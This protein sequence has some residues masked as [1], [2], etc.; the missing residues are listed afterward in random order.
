MPK[1]NAYPKFSSFPYPGAFIAVL[2]VLALIPGWL[3]SGRSEGNRST[4]LA[5]SQ[6][7]SRRTAQPQASAAA[8]T[9][10]WG[11][12]SPVAPALEGGVL[13]AEERRLGGLSDARE[14][15]GSRFEPPGADEFPSGVPQTTEALLEEAEMVAKSA[16]RRY[17]ESILAQA[18]LAYWQTF[19]GQAE[20]AEA[21]WQ[22]ILSRE[23]RFLDAYAE[24]I[25]LAEKRNALGEVVH[26][27]RRV[28]RLAPQTEW[29]YL[30]LAQALAAQGRD[31]EAAAVLQE[32]HAQA[33]KPS[34]AVC[35]MLGG[36]L[37]RLGRVSEA[38]AVLQKAEA[39]APGDPE[40]HRLLADLA[41]SRG[42]AD[43]AEEHLRRASQ[44]VAAQPAEPSGD[45][46]LG[47]LVR[48]VAALETKAGKMYYAHRDFL[49]T[50]IYL[51][52][53][54]AIDPQYIEAHRAL[55]AFYQEQ[56]RYLE[57]EQQLRDWLRVEP[58]NLRIYITLA[59]L[60]GGRRDFAK[61]EA[62]LEEAT[63]K[64]PNNPLPFAMLAKL[65]IDARQKTE[66]AVPLAEKVVA[67]QPIAINY[68]LLAEAFE[69]TGRIPE[70]LAA[71]EKAI[72]L[73]RQQPVFAAVRKRLLDRAGQ[74]AVEN[75][76]RPAD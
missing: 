14:Q 16:V 64:F 67:L 37:V 11:S 22:A 25:K 1:S 41:A 48:D 5:H 20:K 45:D 3:L 8:G 10:P 60:Y 68:Q 66:Q 43:R 46:Q 36:L 72:A 54:V 52:R 47:E 57:M 23:E 62:T 2:F 17:P 35:K 61:T 15:P 4:P 65:Y 51:R 34:A 76:P 55:V 6:G 26:L 53:A 19:T 40:V 13:S 9:A 73:E 30:R 74:G 56:G 59:A 71:I 12:Q 39:E 38:E 24:L 75:P 49:R 63:R 58:D 29:A 70:A 31:E 21:T 18:V 27:T 42:D 28:I 7:E 33:E 44:Q 32:W 69:S 50:E